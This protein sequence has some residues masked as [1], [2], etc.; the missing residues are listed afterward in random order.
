MSQAQ[1]DKTVFT[2]ACGALQQYMVHPGNPFP[3]LIW[4]RNIGSPEPEVFSK[5]SR[6]AVWSFYWSIVCMIVSCIALA[7][8]LNSLN[9]PVVAGGLYGNFIWPVFLTFLW[10]FLVVL[11]CYVKSRMGLLIYAV[12]Q[13]IWTVYGIYG[14]VSYL[15]LIGFYNNLGLHGG[16]WFLMFAI[17][18]PG[19]FFSAALSYWTFKSYQEISN[20]I[21]AQKTE[22]EM[23]PQTHTEQE[24]HEAA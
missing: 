2:G 24:T 23:Q 20:G 10:V 16:I 21:P 12:I 3:L 1:A 5:A 19:V 17:Y 22:Q 8:W 15:I 9:I 14:C 7:V 13:G 11:M 4:C 18:V 6:I